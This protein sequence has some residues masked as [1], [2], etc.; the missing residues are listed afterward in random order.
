MTQ[1][2]LNGGLVLEA[3]RKREAF[4]SVPED[5][6]ELTIKTLLPSE[7]AEL[8]SL[9]HRLKHLKNL[10]LCYGLVERLDFL[11]SFCSIRSLFVG[12]LNDLK[13]YTGIGH[14]VKLT[15]LSLTPSLSSIGSLGFLRHLSELEC[16]RLEGPNPSKGI[17]E[18]GPLRKVK[19]LSLY[20]PRW[21]LEQLPA[22][23]PALENLWISQ[24]G[25]QSLGFIASL[26]RLATLEVYYARKL[27][28]FDSVG[29]LPCLRTLKIGH[30][31][32]GL[33]STAQFGR[34]S[35]VER[36]E[37][38]GCKRLKDVDSL[39][40]WLALKELKIC[41]CPLIPVE[42]LEALRKMGRTVIAR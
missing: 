5:T 18:I 19:E 41:D 35:T 8:L 37:I 24:G 7:A 32:A 4:Q 13:D 34:S 26:E 17:N 42:Q 14:C 27:A 2:E 29:Q 15:R 22:I 23:F 6:Q 3:D 28:A 33:H 11:E 1:N 25:Y 40:D 16:L 31:I 12:H 39:S 21:N 36:I 38:G 10:A 9:G 30:A 20:A